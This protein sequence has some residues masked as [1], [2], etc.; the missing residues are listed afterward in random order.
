M[1][2]DR[3]FLQLRN[4][5]PPKSNGGL[6]VLRQLASYTYK[7]FKGLDQESA[8]TPEQSLILCFVA[9]VIWALAPLCWLG[10]LGSCSSA[11]V[12]MRGP[13]TTTTLSESR[14]HTQTHHRIRD[15]ADRLKFS[16]ESIRQLVKDEP[17]VV[18]IRRGKKAAHT[19]YSVPESVAIRIYARLG[20]EASTFDEEHYRIAD[21][22]SLWGLGR[23]T[24][25]QLIKDEPGVL[26][27]ALGCKG[28][29][30]TYSIPDSILKR[31]HNRL[32]YPV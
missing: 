3:T 13:I 15:L 24:V 9:F 30:L 11:L 19:S 5:S 16:E 2:V 21:V 4:I 1:S 27:L 7:L 17:G 6:W 32:L 8:C 28:A 25:R 14:A 26:K 29:H 23:E 31:I 20:G 18:K 10:A 22:V 12:P